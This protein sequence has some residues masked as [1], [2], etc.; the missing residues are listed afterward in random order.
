MLACLLNELSDEIMHVR[1]TLCAWAPVRTQAGWLP[2]SP[3]MLLLLPRWL[4]SSLRSKDIMENKTPHDLLAVLVN[5]LW[6]GLQAL[7]MERARAGQ[8]GNSQFLV[9]CVDIFITCPP[10]HGPLP[11]TGRQRPGGLF[12]VPTHSPPP[13]VAV[14]IN[15]EEQGQASSGSAPQ[16]HT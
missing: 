13:P 10:V 6:G 16:L 4:K 11:Q 15:V 5:G 3:C 7:A 8:V 12:P 2:L 9:T 14:G 1:H